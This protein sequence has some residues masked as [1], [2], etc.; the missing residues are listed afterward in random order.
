MPIVGACSRDSVLGFRR[1]LA[2]G[3]AISSARLPS[4]EKPISPPVPQATSKGMLC[5]NARRT[6]QHFRGLL[7]SGSK[8][9][10]LVGPPQ[11]P[12]MINNFI[13]G[14]V[15]RRSSAV[16]YATGMLT[17]DIILL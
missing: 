15:R 10:V 7:V 6:L 12:N 4:I 2:I 3:T 8:V 11:R 1:R 17:V 14:M 9:R 13:G 16:P 5:R